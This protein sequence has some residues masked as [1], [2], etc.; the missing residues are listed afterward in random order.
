MPTVQTSFLVA[1]PEN[2]Q[3]PEGSCVTANI[4][5]VTASTASYSN[6]SRVEG[7]VLAKARFVVTG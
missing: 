5:E 1:A 3:T 4:R 2:K 7:V 6:S